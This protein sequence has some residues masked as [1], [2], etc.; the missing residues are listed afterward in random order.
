MKIRPIYV[1]L[2]T[3]LLAGC[4][5]GHDHE[6]HDHEAEGH[7]HESELHHDEEGEEHHHEGAI[8][9]DAKQ[10]ELFGVVSE[11]LLPGDFS[12]VIRVSGVIEP[13][14]TDRVTLSA[15][16]SGIFTLARGVTVGSAVA[17]GTSIGSISSKGLQGGDPNAVA[18]ATVVAAKK[19]VDR[20][21][22]L[23]KD[24]LVTEAAYNEAV[25][26]YNEAKA[27]QGGVAGGSGS[28]TSPTGGT[29]SELFVSSGQ[30]VE[31][32]APVALVVKSSRLTLRAD[33]PERYITSVPSFVSANFRPDCSKKTF[34]LKDLGGKP[35]S[36]GSVNPVRNGYVPV[37]FSFDGNGE[38]IPGTFAEI[39]LTGM[40]RQGV[41]S[42]P[43][44]ALIEMQGN[45][46]AYV[47][48]HGHK[49]TFEKRLVKTGASDGIKVEVL[50]GLSSGDEVIVKGAS[51]VRMA[52]TSAIAPP[53]HSHNH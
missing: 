31:V 20:L 24:G 21:A 36:S 19:E 43:R 47:R 4:G 23:Y 13:A 40:V 9:L 8:T 51:V 1:L 26:N 53:G 48:V 17:A 32:G 35:L 25:K 29:L 44:E 45:H 12:E 5:G 38:I 27:A 3:A 28:V 11:K 7:D 50:D 30:Y 14:S 37:Y 18:A 52:E 34:R 22:P 41:L 6:G 42:I 15:T 49:N 10:A 46:Y 39:F 2:M 33:V 16:R